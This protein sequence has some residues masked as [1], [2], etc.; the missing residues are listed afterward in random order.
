VD[1][2]IS[3][4]SQIEYLRASPQVS[5]LVPEIFG[6]SS[7]GQHEE[8]CSNIEFPPVIEHQIGNVLLDDISV[9]VLPPIYLLLYLL[10]TL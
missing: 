1:E 2:K 9:G 7:N 6:G 8:V 3:K 5:L 4:V 10:A